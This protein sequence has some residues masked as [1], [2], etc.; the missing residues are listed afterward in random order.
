MMKK[1]QAVSPLHK[2][3]KIILVGAALMILLHMALGLMM[4]GSKLNESTENRLMLYCES[5]LLVAVLGCCGVY[6]LL[7]KKDQAAWQ[8][9]GQRLRR[10]RCPEMAVLLFMLGYYALLC[11]V[12]A[13]Q[14]PGSFSSAHAYLVDMA[15]CVLL[16]FPMAMVLG[17][18]KARWGMDKLLHLLVICFTAF[19]LWA[20][21]VLF[22]GKKVMM[23][24]GQ[25]VGMRNGNQFQ[26][27]ANANISAAMCTAMV[28]ICLY[29]IA[30]GKGKVKILYAAALV[31]HLMT[32]LYTNSRGHFFAL[33]V[34]VPL[35][36]LMVL[37]HKTKGMH[38][39]WRLV[40]SC[41]GA[42]AAAVLMTLL[43][44]WVFDLYHAIVPKGK[45]GGTVRKDMTVDVARQKIWHSTIKHIFS[46]P[47]AFLLGTPV[48]QI[49]QAIEQAMAGLYGTGHSFVHAHNVILHA[50]LVMGFPGMAAMV[51]LFVMLFVRCLRVLLGKGKSNPAGA[52]VLPICMLGMVV[53]NMFESFLLFFLSLMGC[54]FF[55]YA[56]WV[57]S[58]DR[59]DG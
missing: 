23:P 19:V 25:M 24:G 52:Y 16:L 38:V 9:T 13:I 40:I 47:R 32:V 28:M 39:L 2:W 49:P 31:P 20:L 15:V 18:R 14:Y 7:A 29:M 21:W 8:R 58:L 50:G 1:K 42:V 34:M 36:V 17:V 56:G 44:Q 12:N 53:I 26:I 37:W 5:A 27:G 54:L 48:S 4:S 3:K 35:L 41:A 43:R 30:M 46:S 33:W 59:L 22:N 11:L 10:L 45:G 55:L 51:A 6:L 57:V